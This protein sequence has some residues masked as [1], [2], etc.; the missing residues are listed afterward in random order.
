VLATVGIERPYV[1]CTLHRPSN[2][3]VA[4]PLSAI[5]S[6]LGALARDFD[7]VFPLHPRTRECVRRL[8]LDA[9]LAPLKVTEP[10]AYTTMLA[11]QDRAAAVITDSGGIQEETTVL[12]IPCVTV[13]ESTER[14]VT[15]TSGTN[16]LAPWPLEERTLLEAVR[17][18]IAGPRRPGAPRVPDGWDGLASERI[19]D[20]LLTFA[21][22]IHAP[23]TSAV[24]L[25]SPAG[26]AAR[27][28]Q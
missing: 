10:L 9:L 4:E 23:A 5:L 25:A 27:S 28:S 13:R 15:I 22:G 14:P 17:G 7:I 18:A 19:V 24:A 1:V 3:D 12:G 8:G 21:G 6:V 11:L 26:W 20:A 16:Q 2:V